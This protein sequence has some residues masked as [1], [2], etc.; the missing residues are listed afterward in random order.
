MKAHHIFV[1]FVG[2]PIM[3]YYT[4]TNSSTGEISQVIDSKTEYNS[5]KYLEPNEG[6]TNFDENP[7]EAK[8]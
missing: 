2:L 5:L 6:V 7:N 8:M 1:K 4:I 3:L